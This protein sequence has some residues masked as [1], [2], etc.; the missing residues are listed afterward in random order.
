M[1]DTLVRGDRTATG[2]PS[3]YQVN[4]SIPEEVKVLN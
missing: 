2:A 4:Q 3:A 1:K